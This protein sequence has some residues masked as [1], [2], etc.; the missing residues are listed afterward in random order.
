MT[1]ES[2]ESARNANL[3][4]RCIEAMLTADWQT[5]FNSYATDAILVDPLL[6][7]PVRG[8]NAI[9]ALYQQ[10]REHEPDMVGEILSLLAADDKVSV[11]FRTSGTI[12]KPFPDMPETIVGKRVEIQE[13]NII[14]LQQGQI[15]SN[16]IYADTGALMRQLDL[17]PT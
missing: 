7:D 16:V 2:T 5:V 14:Q 1:M 9:V 13:V 4:R 6:P 8:R 10:C 17:L 15:V 12:Q 3:V 11:E